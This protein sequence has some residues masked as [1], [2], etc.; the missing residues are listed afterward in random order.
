MFHV[1]RLIAPNSLTYNKKI[2]NLPKNFLS[3]QAKQTIQVSQKS[4]HSDELNL[5][6]PCVKRLKEI[7]DTDKQY[8]KVS[9]EAGGCS[10][11]NYQFTLESKI[12]DQDL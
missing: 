12:S 6:D 1:R 3:S 7:Y 11:L 2:F 4:A 5:S 8:L 9:V 10:G